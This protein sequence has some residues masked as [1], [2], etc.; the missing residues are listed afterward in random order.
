MIQ[1]TEEN[2]KIKK[3]NTRLSKNEGVK[4]RQQIEAKNEEIRTLKS[5]IFEYSHEQGLQLLNALKDSGSPA[6]SEQ[7]P[8]LSM[9]REQTLE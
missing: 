7:N 9:S 6:K 1:M 4:Y 5:K 8:H 3:E 2:N